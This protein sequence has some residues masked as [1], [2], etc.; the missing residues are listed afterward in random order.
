MNQQMIDTYHFQFIGRQPAINAFFNLRSLRTQKNALYIEADGGLGKTRVLREYI[1]QC[2]QQRRPWHI[3]PPGDEIDPIIDFYD[4]QNRTVAGLRHSIV[5]RLG[6]VYFLGFSRRD[7]ELQQAEIALKAGGTKETVLNLRPEVDRLFYQELKGALRGVGT[8]TALLF[9]TFEAVYNRRVGRWFLEEFLPHPAA[10]GCLIVFAGRPRSF[11]LPLNVF[12]HRLEPFTNDEAAEYFSHKWNIRRDEPENAVRE[13][14]GGRP[15]LMDLVV[16]YARNLNGRIDDLRNKPLPDVERMLVA[17]FL[18]ADTPV[19]EVIQ[20]MAYLKRRYNSTIFERRR[21]QYDNPPSYE[22]LGAELIAL[23]FIKHRGQDDSFILHDEFQ[24]M[25]AD[26]GGPDWQALTQDLYHEIVLDWYMQAIKTASVEIERDLLRVEQLVYILE[27]DRETGLSQYRAYFEDIKANHLFEF[28]DLLWG[29]VAEHLGS[30]RLAYDLSREQANWLF[31]NSRYQEAA[32]LF[33]QTTGD[34]FTGVYAGEMLAQDTVRLGHC[35]LRLGDVVQTGAVFKWGLE[36][37]RQSANIREQALFEYNLGHVMVRRGQWVEALAS[38]ESATEH[39]RDAQDVELIGETLLVMARLRAQQGDYGRA[40]GEMERSLRL[41]GR[42]FAGQI[43]QA[44]AFVYAGDTYR[45]A[46]DTGN[47]LIHYQQAGRILSRLPGWH[48]WRVDAQAGLG[49]TYNLSGIHKRTAGDLEGDLYDQIRAFDLLN[50]SLLQTREHNLGSRLMI[51]LDRLAEVYVETHQL[52]ILARDDSLVREIA[53]FRVQI[54]GLILVEEINLAHML[55]EP[56]KPFA[57]LDVLGQ[58]QRLFEIAFLHSDFMREPHRMFDSLTQ[59]ASVAQQRGHK[60]DLEHYAILAGTLH[61]LDDP[62]QERMFFALLEVLYTHIE[63]KDSPSTAIQRYAEAMIDLAP[64]PGG[65]GWSLAQKQLPEIEKRL[66][67][68]D[69][70]I[71]VS[72]CRILESTWRG[73]PHLLA[74][75]QEVEDMIVGS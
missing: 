67:G 13:I 57:E 12:K 35:Y 46:G 17:K 64:N 16:H 23:P 20:D 37:A 60:G 19:Y 43:R 11:D 14:S 52:D 21:S 65:S 6:V 59:A 71:V 51:V 36:R 10:A 39:A 53:Q 7:A 58:A 45:Y 22:Q 49:A 61:G 32:P 66:L 5:E 75:V 63:F 34:R 41:I 62:A 42:Q 38:Y 1:T 74:F 48:D 9:D 68:L 30:N 24:R 55:H 54:Q 56:E 72:S 25:I 31:E 2:K 44:Q 4:L 18:T 28:N 8:Y 29:E 70:S 15:L 69:K 50:Q 40:F 47:A 3:Q 27:R 33:S 73:Y 26:H